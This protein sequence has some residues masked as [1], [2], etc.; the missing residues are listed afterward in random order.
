[1]DEYVSKA[2]LNMKEKTK[3]LILLATGGIISGLSVAF[4]K[5][6]GFLIWISLIPLFFALRILGDRENLKMK[7]AYLYGLFY[8]ECFYAVCFHFFFSMYP[9]DFTGLNEFYSMLV[10]V[11]ACFGLSFLQALFGGLVFV[12][13]SL[14]R[15]RSLVKNSPI[16]SILSFTAI[17]T[18]Y[19]FTQTLGWWGVP[20]GRLSLALTDMIIPI[21]AA[22][23]FGSY[24]ITAIIVTVN[25]LLALSLIKFKSVGIE[26]KYALAALC[27]FLS[28]IALGAILFGAHKAT[29]KNGD[30]VKVGIIQG[31]YDSTDKWFEPNPNVIV[32]DHLNLTEKAAADGAEIVL[33]AETSIPFVL[34]DDDIHSMRISNMA[35]ELDITI[36]V[37]AIREDE[38]FIYNALV[39]FTPDG[40]I[41]KTEYHKRHLV[42][43]GEYVPMRRLIELALPFMAEISTLSD[44][45]TPGTDSAILNL[46]KTNAGSLICFDSIYENLT[47]DTV[48][49]GAETIMLSTNDSW[50]SDSAAA[51][52]HNNQA[53]FRAVEFGRYIA[54]SANTGL[55]TFISNTGEVIDEI[56]PLTEDH[57]CQ[58]LV[59]LNTRTLYSRIGNVFVYLCGVSILVPFAYDLIM[60]LKANKTLQNGD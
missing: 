4:S 60:K 47:R 21:Q 22:S 56:P 2:D 27:V 29:Q 42:P 58:D 54:R 18:F 46:E 20:W 15:Q 11:I 16:V 45:M 50:F 13:Y 51:Y 32:S 17:Y 6:V 48:K 53:R 38:E 5:Y 24:F 39:C 43:F 41:S 30:T 33:W 34:Y 12:V 59:N 25:S 35:D 31:N 44:D 3:I 52:M 28:N 57:L 49:A 37:G 55:S 1:M 40:K 9:L 36:L 23:L 26:K 8:F 14:I 19:E 7:H 10:V